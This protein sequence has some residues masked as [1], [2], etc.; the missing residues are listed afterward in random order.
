MKNEI[1]VSNLQLNEEVLKNLELRKLSLEGSLTGYASIDK[2][3]LKYYTDEHI[4]A[5]IPNMTAYDYLKEMNK[6]NLDLTAIDS[7]FGNYTYKEL[8][9][10]IDN[11]AKSLYQL[12]VKKGDIVME[13]LPILPHE[14]FLLYGVD[15]VGAA[16]APLAPMTTPDKICETINKFKTRVFVTFEYFLNPEIE[17]ILYENTCLENII[18]ISLSSKNSDER[19][20]NWDQFIENGK[21]IEMPFINRN[22]KDL[23]FL[24]STGGST[25]EP[26][27]VMLNDN[28]FNIIVHQFI[29]SD[30][31]YKAGDKWIRLWPIFSASAAISNHHLP[32]CTGACDLLR[33]FPQD[34][35]D[36]D[37]IIYQ[38]KPNH[39]IM[40]PQLIDVL[41]QSQLLK[42]ENM[43]Y[44]KTAGCG[45][46]AITPQFEK[47]V[48]KFYKE[49]NMN[50]FLGYGWGCT[51]ASTS[52]AMRSNFATTKIGT[53]GAPK[54]HTVVAAFEPGTDIE[55][56]YNEQGELCV[57]SHT[58]MMGYY[59]D[60]KLTNQVLLRHSDGNI[61]L[62]T[63]DLGFVSPDGLVTVNGRMSR[64]IFIYPTAKIYPQAMEADVSKV[65]GVQEV[66]VC[67][68]PDKE[69]DGFYEPVCIIVPD[70]NYEIE[71]TILRVKELFNE[72]YKEFE[73][74]RQI[75]V[76]DTL[77][78]TKVGKPNVIELEK[79]L[80]SD[81]NEYVKKLTK[82]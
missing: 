79:E 63:G 53:A 62:H 77:P 50:T 41:E 61:W 18:N 70:N 26:K 48:N 24:A 22:S 19:T 51:E 39:S 81:D 44:V 67:Q 59:N 33:A 45:G 60:E 14:S 29:N 54:V 27:S 13:M 42:N 8:F 69:H 74:P 65:L 56:K 75:I 23:L 36:F 40:I 55:K 17:K 38:D 20:I 52:I 37:K 46:L 80:I 34:I 73:R 6:G 47:R 82:C 49:H 4:K 58:L 25:G 2:P 3:W 68:V 71:E 10:N 5:K 9:E 1:K 66:V 30:L 21:N 31:D 57:K 76:K 72:K 78:L 15:K 16:L 28:C 64:M 11:C 12:G 43:N 7:Q 32:L 35:K